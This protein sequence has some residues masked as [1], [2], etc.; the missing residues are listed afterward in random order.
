MKEIII[1]LLS[2][3]IGFMIC[4]NLPEED[5]IEYRDKIIYDTLIKTVEH[6][7]IKIEAEP[8]IIIKRDTIIKI[9]P[10][11][12]VLDTVYIRDT[13][14]AIYDYP[15]NIFRLDITKQ[16]DTIFIPAETIIKYKKM[17]WYYDAGLFLAGSATGYLIG[18][19][20]SK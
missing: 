6:K 5:T 18:N 17:P 3:V 4:C 15:E 7:P 8:K 12:A 10:F 13:I 19:T 20:R 1:A 11:T 16:N 14:K 9:K 2:A